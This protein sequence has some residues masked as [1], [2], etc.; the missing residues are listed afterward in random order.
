MAIEGEEELKLDGG[1][2][3]GRVGG[4]RKRIQGG[5]RFL[6]GLNGLNGGGDVREHGKQSAE[7][8]TRTHM[9]WTQRL[10]DR[11]ADWGKVEADASR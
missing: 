5:G 4:G 1:F 8:K 11:A 3:E 7:R 6:L 9:T 2:E 10:K